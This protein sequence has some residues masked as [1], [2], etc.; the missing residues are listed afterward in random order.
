MVECP[1]LLKPSPQGH[2][3]PQVPE[4]PHCTCCRPRWRLQSPCHRSFL[5]KEIVVSHGKYP[6][7]IEI[8]QNGWFIIEN[9]WT[10]TP[11]MMISYDFGVPWCSRNPKTF[12]QSSK[13][14]CDKT[15]NHLWYTLPF[16]VNVWAMILKLDLPVEIVDLPNYN[17]LD[18]SSSLRNSLPEGNHTIKWPLNF[19]WK[20]VIFHGYVIVCQRVLT[21]FLTETITES[22]GQPWPGRCT[23]RRVT[24]IGRPYIFDLCM[25]GAFV[26]YDLQ[27]VMNYIY[28]MCIYIYSVHVCVLIYI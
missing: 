15:R 20:V 27:Y 16:L 9:H 2:N 26:V 19:P 17:M 6:K 4:M 24:A 3:G 11:K 21:R 14:W 28:N 25:I 13:R 23:T 8:S 22:Q 10:S 12:P 7:Y 18:L 5:R 1:F